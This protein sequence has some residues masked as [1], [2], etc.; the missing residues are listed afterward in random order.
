M[1]TPAFGWCLLRRFPIRWRLPDSRFG[2]TSPP[3]TPRVSWPV[4]QPCPRRTDPTQVRR[5]YPSSGCVQRPHNPSTAPNGGELPSNGV[6]REGLVHGHPSRERRIMIRPAGARA[7]TRNTGH[8]YGIARRDAARAAVRASPA[9]SPGISLPGGRRRAAEDR[10]PR[11]SPMDTMPRR[12]RAS[13]RLRDSTPEACRARS[14]PAPS[15]A[16][17]DVAAAL[18]ASRW[19]GGPRPATPCAPV[20]TSPKP[21]GVTPTDHVATPSYVRSSPTRRTAAACSSP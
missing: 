3:E 1:R 9:S 21:F 4:Q 15:S 16:R 6:P 7:N 2:A 13:L 19:H 10:A 20:G 14:R 11:S 8:P 12:D 18:S 5:C 17:R